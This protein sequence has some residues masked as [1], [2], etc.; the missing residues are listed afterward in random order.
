MMHCRSALYPSEPCSGGCPAA[1][2][3]HVVALAKMKARRRPV[4]RKVGE[5]FQFLKLICLPT[6]SLLLFRRRLAEPATLAATLFGADF[7]QPLGK[8]DKAGHLHPFG[9]NVAHY[10][11]P[12]A[13]RI[14]PRKQK[15][16]ANP[17]DYDEYQK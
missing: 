7:D 4:S 17:G 5:A 10:L 1:P 2:T 13:V 6:D 8:E 14:H 9:D 12:F 15:S 3:R 16:P 11:A